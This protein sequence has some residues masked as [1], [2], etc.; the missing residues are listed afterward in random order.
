MPKGLFK[1]F[2]AEAD[3]LE[4]FVN[5]QVYLTPPKYFNDPWDFMVLSEPP[6]EILD[7]QHPWLSPSSRAEILAR[8]STAHVLHEVS[9]ELQN[10]YSQ[11][12][13]VVCL[14]QL[15]LDRLMWAHY[16]E[17]HH[18]FVA[19]FTR[20]DVDEQDGFQCAMT[21]FG[22]ALKVKYLS[23]EKVLKGDCSNGLEVTNTKNTCWTYEQEW[24]VT[25]PLLEGIPHPSKKGYVLLPFQPSQLVR[26][27]LGLRAT[28]DV[29]SGLREMLDG[30]EYKNVIRE[31]VIIDPNTRELISSASTW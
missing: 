8:M 4:R 17:S 25:R 23:S 10:R 27:V 9:G 31:T 13:G 30:K 11:F 16:G 7:S 3:K 22:A 24:R 29:R 12:F 19:E 28:N 5:G 15:P 2:G 1:Y 20:S 18:G 14:N 26:I 21:P 6:E